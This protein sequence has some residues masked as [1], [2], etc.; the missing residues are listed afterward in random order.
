MVPQEYGNSVSSVFHVMCHAILIAHLYS[1]NYRA[2]CL[3][4][5]QALIRPKQSDEV[6]HTQ[7]ATVSP[8]QV[9]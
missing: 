8:Q 3:H 9:P 7:Y 2:H 4:F 6:T 1:L 5:L